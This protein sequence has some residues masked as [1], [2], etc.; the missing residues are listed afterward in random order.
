[1]KVIKLDLKPNTQFHLGGNTPFL[2]SVLHTTD[3]IIRSDTLFSAII[4]IAAKIGAAQQLI[5]L[6]KE[7]AVSISSGF[8][9]ISVKDK[10]I[11]FFPRPTIPLSNDLEVKK[12]K[13]IKFVSPLVIQDYSFNDWFNN[14]NLINGSNWIATK[15]EFSELF[16]VEKNNFDSFVKSNLSTT[17][18]NIKFYQTQNI[19]QVCVHQETQ[20]DS[21]YQNTNL[22]ISDNRYIHPDLNIN[23]YFLLKGELSQELNQTLALL[24]DEN[25]GGQKSTGCGQIQDINIYDDDL[26]NTINTDNKYQMSLSLISPDI[27]NNENN[28]L[29]EFSYYQTILRGG[30]TTALDGK[31]N[32]IRMITEG[33]IL[34]KNIT[35]NI[36]K[37]GE[38]K[39]KQDYLRYGK[40]FYIPINKSYLKN[41]KL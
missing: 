40:A 27:K 21:F 26:F 29:D 7:D 25:I 11:Y 39:E 14:G 22:F 30:R 38:S 10:N 17:P 19:P 18:D 28:S 2:D 32:D 37:L 12:I 1:M 4:N 6:F 3:T 9:M 24:K 33:A 8:Y 41:D 35:G 13:K 31:L 36:P 34:N 23:F 15:E 5:D 16:S 20:E